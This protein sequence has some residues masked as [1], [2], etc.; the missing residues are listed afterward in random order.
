VSRAAVFLDRDGVLN[1]LVN[2][3]STG[4]PESPLDEASVE[5]IDG[6]AQAALKLRAAGYLLVGVTNQPAAAKQTVSR[7][8]LEAV[9]HE[10]IRQLGELGLELDAWRM[11]LHHPDGTDPVLSGPCDC[12]KPAPGMLFD[13]ANELDIDLA[14]SWMVGDSDSD[15][16]AGHAAGTRTISIENPQSQHKRLYPDGADLQALDLRQ[17]VAVLLDAVTGD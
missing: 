17:A 3:P 5:L 16:D 7:D 15:I 8:K 2:D 11:C 14:T 9:H 6:A 4:L 1:V 13:A 10:V 12:R